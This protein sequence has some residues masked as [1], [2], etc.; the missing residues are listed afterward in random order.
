[1]QPDILIANQRSGHVTSSLQFHSKTYMSSLRPLQ[2]DMPV[3][4]NAF[5]YD[6]LNLRSFTL[7]FT[8][9]TQLSLQP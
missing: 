8:T 1:M 6:H 9:D 4:L 3:S 5:M 2:E 7:H